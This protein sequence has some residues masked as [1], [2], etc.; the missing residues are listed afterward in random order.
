MVHP[1][2]D[3]LMP[4]GQLKRKK[5][6]T[7]GATASLSTWGKFLYYNVGCWSSFFTSSRYLPSMSQKSWKQMCLFSWKCVLLVHGRL[8]GR[9]VTTL[10]ILQYGK[11]VWESSLFPLILQ[12]VFSSLRKVV[13]VAALYAGSPKASWRKHPLLL[14]KVLAFKWWWVD[15]E[16]KS[17]HDALDSHFCSY[18]CP[19]K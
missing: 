10:Q 3:C 2:G 14:W 9:L 4:T 8:S 15:G 16:A 6:C 11:A 18:S 19:Q 17:L 5:E 7:P 13:T 1:R 12:L